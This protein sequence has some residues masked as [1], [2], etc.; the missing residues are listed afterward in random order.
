MRAIY[1]LNSVDF[2]LLWNRLYSSPT[3]F[4][5]FEHLVCMCS[6]QERSAVIVTL[7]Y[8]HVYTLSRVLLPRCSGVW[9]I[10]LCFLL[11]QP[12]VEL[13]SL[14]VTDAYYDPVPDHLV[15]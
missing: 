15:V 6:D 10:G 8:L 9:A 14:G 3:D 1:K 7:R 11:I 13:E 2:A 5:A 12:G 4:F